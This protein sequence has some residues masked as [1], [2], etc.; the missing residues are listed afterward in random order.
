MYACICGGVAFGY[1][2]ALGHMIGLL[3]TRTFA[4]GARESHH[5]V[6][7]DRPEQMGC[8]AL[9][10]PVWTHSLDPLGTQTLF[11]TKCLPTLLGA[12]VPL[13]RNDCHA[14]QLTLMTAVKH[15]VNQCWPRRPPLLDTLLATVQ[16][17]LTA[18]EATAWQCTCCWQRQACVHSSTLCT[19]V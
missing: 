12:F 4:M 8:L 19:D 17:P 18:A 14:R 3:V 1:Y 10:V 9:L 2:F 5:A 16:K 15:R 6:T 7:S 13:V 11:V